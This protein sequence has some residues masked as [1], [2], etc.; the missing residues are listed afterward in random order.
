M[1]QTYNHESS[2]SIGDLNRLTSLSAGIPNPLRSF[3]SQVLATTEPYQL[4][5]QPKSIQHHSFTP[6]QV[7]HK[8]LAL[9][10]EEERKMAN[11][12]F[13]RMM[14]NLK[15]SQYGKLM[16]LHSQSVLI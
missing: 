2:V 10:G 16:K 14:K 5:V 7:E 9:S 1:K 12:S 13:L 3:V 4:A 11:E 15:G 6:A 8:E